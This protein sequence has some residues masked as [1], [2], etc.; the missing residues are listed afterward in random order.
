MILK[1]FTLSNNYKQLK[2]NKMK[3]TIKFAKA[4]IAICIL[5]FTLIGTTSCSKSKI[6]P[7][8][9]VAQ[10]L[11]GTWEKQ[12]FLGNN[13]SATQIT[14]NADGT[15]VERTFNLND[16]ATQISNERLFRFTWSLKS[17]TVFH[18]KNEVDE[19]GDV[20]FFITDD[21]SALRLTMPGGNSIILGRPN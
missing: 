4:A 13:I 16:G 2:Q 20:T 12:D 8:G 18:L 10:N 14:F 21:K 1:N 5:C 9:S 17:S 11:L 6:G 15:G 3:T 7:N 19:E